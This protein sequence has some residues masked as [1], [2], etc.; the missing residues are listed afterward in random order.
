MKKIIVTGGS[1]FI[2]TNFIFHQLTNTSNKVL[3]YDKLTYAGNTQN[4]KENKENENYS[5]IEGDIADNVKIKKVFSTFKPDILVNFAAETHVDRSIDGP[6]VFVNTNIV[7]TLNLLKVSQQWIDSN[8]SFK[9][10]HVSTDEVYG[11]LNTNDLPFTESHPYKPNS[12]YSASK[13]SSDFFVRAWHKTHG[14]STIITNCSNN[15][16]PYQFTEKLIPLMIANCLDN[17][18]LPIYGNGEN[19]RDWLY[20]EDHCNAITLVLENGKIGETYNLGGNNEI[21]NIDIVQN[22][23]MILDKLKPRANKSSYKQLITYVEDRPGHDFRYAIDS[24]KIQKTLEW[25]PI[26]SFETGIYKTI[27]WYLEN[28]PWWRKIQKKYYNQERLGLKDT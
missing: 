20:V 23:C 25:K 9:F 27:E 17:K 5:F 15:Y 4:H 1:G 12:P 7:G 18:P 22:I 3:N 2:G 6:E 28:E 10:I 14:L 26:E 16:G 21:K 11:S 24:S 8:P 13:A 19:I